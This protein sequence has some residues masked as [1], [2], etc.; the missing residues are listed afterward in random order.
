M[1]RLYIIRHAKSSW[2]NNQLSDFDRPLNDRG[3]RDAP[4]IGEVLKN[5]KVKPDLVISSSAKRALTTAKILSDIIGYPIENIEESYEIYET[6]TQNLL[7]V[8]N[9]IDDIYNSV[10]IFGHNPGFTRLANL[11]GDKYIENLPTC[12]VAEIELDV[13]SW[14]DVGIDSGKLVSFEYPK[15]YNK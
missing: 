2:A 3:N 5:K 4:I 10:I 9:D 7:D 11:L 1:K 12:A 8:V 13:D 15:K 14:E 6:T